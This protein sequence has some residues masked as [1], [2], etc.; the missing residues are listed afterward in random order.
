MTC[1]PGQDSPLVTEAADDVRNNTD[2]ELRSGIL[3]NPCV[4]LFYVQRRRELFYWY[5]IWNQICRRKRWGKWG[6]C[7][8]GFVKA[9]ILS[10]LLRR[11]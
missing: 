4:P 8:G 1:R 10:L 2:E 7:V 9:H 3:Q 11:F 6:K 5:A